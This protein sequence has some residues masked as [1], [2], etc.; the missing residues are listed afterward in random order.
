MWTT[1]DL[2]IMPVRPGDAVV[3]CHAIYKDF[4]PFKTFAS[5]SVNAVTRMREAWVPFYV[6]RVIPKAVQVR[7]AYWSTPTANTNAC[8]LPST[9]HPIP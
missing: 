1:T 7:I 2:A 4:D 9:L 5:A 6:D 8:T 3:P